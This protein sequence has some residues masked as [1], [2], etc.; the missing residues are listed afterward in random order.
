MASK[1]T[2]KWS[3]L[4]TS[5]GQV[6]EKAHFAVSEVGSNLKG[7]HLEK[8][9]DAKVNCLGSGMRLEMPESGTTEFK[10]EGDFDGDKFP[11]VYEHNEDHITGTCTIYT[12][13]D[14]GKANVLAIDDWEADKTT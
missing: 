2:P 14:R 9:E 3:S 12:Q 7:K 8:R 1:C 13:D 10:Y 5:G 6:T 4:R 11:G